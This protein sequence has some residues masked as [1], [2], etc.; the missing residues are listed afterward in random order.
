VPAALR[1]VQRPRSA[2]TV[3]H[4]AAHGSWSSGRVSS[5]VTDGRTQPRCDHAAVCAVRRGA[6][7]ARFS[8]AGDGSRGAAPL[9]R[10]SPTHMC[11]CT[12]LT[13]VT[14]PK[15]LMIIPTRTRDGGSSSG[16]VEPSQMG[17][18]RIGSE[19]AH[20]RRSWRVRG[21]LTQY[22][23]GGRGA[24]GPASSSTQHSDE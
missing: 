14:R 1:L 24:D 13:H 15:L 2:G 12:D 10:R 21:S 19:L 23:E 22:K 7:P 20:A 17:R 8:V 16:A 5:P 9:L 4:I 18:I 3:R 6:P 11:M